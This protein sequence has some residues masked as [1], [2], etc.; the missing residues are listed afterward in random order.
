MT[1][2]ADF[3]VG[4]VVARPSRPWIAKHG[5][6]AR[7]TQDG[8][9]PP[10]WPG[11]GAARASAAAATQKHMGRSP[12]QVPTARAAQRTESSGLTVLILP[13]MAPMGTEVT[14]P[15]R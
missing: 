9:R 6:D 1:L 3:V 5:R 8:S 14:P 4:G 11:L 10:Q 15:P 12:K 2:V 13:A 7:V